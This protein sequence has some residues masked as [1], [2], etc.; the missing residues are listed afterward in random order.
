MNPLIIIQI[1]GAVTIGPI[2][3]IGSLYQLVWT[4]RV[5]RELREWLAKNDVPSP[6]VSAFA[7]F[8]RFATMTWCLFIFLLAASISLL[9]M[10]QNQ[11]EQLVLTFVGVMWCLIQL[12]ISYPSTTVCRSLEKLMMAQQLANHGPSE[13]ATWGPPEIESV[14]TLRERFG[15]QITS[16]SNSASAWLYF[17]VASFTIIGLFVLVNAIDQ[18]GSSLGPLLI[19]GG[20]FVGTAMLVLS[21][22]RWTSR[23]QAR[24][25]QLL[26][27]LALTV[28]KQR[29]LAAELATWAKSHP[30][31]NRER[32]L[33]VAQAMSQGSTLADA[34][35]AQPKLLPEST[36]L[37]IRVAEQTG[38]LSDALR[39]LDLRQTKSL[40][41]DAVNSAAGSCL[42]LW[43]MMAVGANIVMYLMYFIVPKF[44]AIFHGFGTELPSVT[45]ALINVADF[46]VS[47]WFVFLP[48]FFFVPLWMFGEAFTRGWSETRLSWWLGFGRRAEVPRLLRRLHDAVAAKLPWQ[49]A[50]QPMVLHH[51]QTD[52]RGR[53]ER[54]LG[55]VTAGMGIWTALREVGL[56]NARDVGLLEVAERAGNLPWALIALAQAKERRMVHRRRVAEAVC[57]PICVITFGLL[58]GFVCFGFFMPMVKLLNDLS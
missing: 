10:P 2:L 22:I 39:D 6:D 26:W 56:L 40:R 35:A 23:F 36:V 27:F 19:I 32:L 18:N 51:H 24:R 47:Y 46:F 50:L 7:K 57:V 45:V 29:P 41:G 13:P 20:V 48:L 17:L 21:A 54:V 53:L 52:I 14:E 28:R 38:M 37:S 5:I 30:G 15:R 58:V 4:R 12:A 31:A 42:Y 3:A 11:P 43:A 49:T 33:A 9:P 44:K 16:V 1:I 8:N 34:L 25:A 55:R